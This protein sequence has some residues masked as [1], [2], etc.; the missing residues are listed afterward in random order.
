ML[1]IP[2][3]LFSINIEK[4]TI[5]GIINHPNSIID[6]GAYLDS[7]CFYMKAHRCL[8]DVIRDLIFTGQKP[9][10]VIIAQKVKEYGIHMDM[11]VYDYLDAICSTQIQPN[12]IKD[13]VK[14]LV[15]L[16]IKRDLWNNASAIQSY[17]KDSPNDGYD[18][19][20]AHV[21]SLY[22]EQISQ[23]HSDEDPIDLYGGI[24]ELIEKNARNPIDETGLITPFPIWNN[25]FG[26]LIAQ[27]G[28]YFISARSGEGKSA[29]MF[30]MAKGVS[31]ANNAKVLILDTEMSADLNMYRAASAASQVNLWYLRT[32]QWIKRPEYVTKV[33]DSFPEINKYKGSIY[34]MYV[35]NRDI[36]E[37]E[38]IMK[39]WYYKVVGRGNPAL[40][41]YDYLKITSDLEKNRQEWQQLGDKVS[42]L[43]EVGHKLNCPIIAAGQQNREAVGQHGRNDDSITTGASDRINQYCCFGSVFREKTQDEISEH[44]E[45]NGSHILN[46]FKV[47]RTTGKD[48]YHNHRRVRVVDPATNRTKFKKNFINYEISKYDVREINTYEDVIIQQQLQANLQPDNNHH[49]KTI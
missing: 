1:P 9:E 15:R 43:N 45:Q 35:P 41:V 33:R 44:G 17:L 12:G 25:L 21:D 26:G 10:K 34:Y 42:I 2:D 13:C 27:N 30:N 18:R 8:F 32:G 31:L 11:D 20:I 7:N 23:F 16:K 49:H 3:S 38:S 24:V 47:S 4:T 48:D 28:I 46:P 40:F 29:F 22:N 6:L 36:H 37:I 5:A 39:R 19:I 14:E